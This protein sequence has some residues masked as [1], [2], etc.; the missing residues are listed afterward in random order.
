MVRPVAQ[1]VAASPYAE[2]VIAWDLINEPEWAI[3]GPGLYGGDEDF[4]PDAELETVTHAQMETFVSE[5]IAVL[6]EES[7][8]LITVGGAAMKWKSAWTQVDVDFYQLHIYDWVNGYWPYSMSP[9][10][11]GIDDMG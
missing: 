5:A 2:R 1:A 3:A 11:Y 6:R 4:D 8:A 9:S 7:D 10:D